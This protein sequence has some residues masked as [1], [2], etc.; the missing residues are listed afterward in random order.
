MELIAIESHFQYQ[1]NAL[2][3]FLR[4]AHDPKLAGR[5][6]ALGDATKSGF[7]KVQKA[8]LGAGARIER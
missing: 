8:T 6:G 3:T 2:G 4:K 1:L 5:S 7:S